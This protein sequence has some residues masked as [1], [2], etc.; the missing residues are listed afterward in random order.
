MVDCSMDAVFDLYF[1]LVC[2]LSFSFCGA[3]SLPTKCV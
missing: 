2:N 3:L 1:S